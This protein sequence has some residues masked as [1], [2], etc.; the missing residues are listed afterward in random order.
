M[1]W[2]ILANPKTEI[3]VQSAL[4]YL[5]IN[6]RDMRPRCGPPG[7]HCTQMTSAFLSLMIAG[8]PWPPNSTRHTGSWIHFSFWGPHILCNAGC[9]VMG[10]GL[11]SHVDRPPSRIHPWS[12]SCDTDSSVLVTR[13]RPTGFVNSQLWPGSP[14][15]SLTALMLWCH[16]YRISLN[17][18]WLDVYKCPVVFR[19]CLFFFQFRLPLQKCCLLAQQKTGFREC[20]ET[21]PVSPLLVRAHACEEQKGKEPVQM[22]P[23]ENWAQTLVKQFVFPKELEFVSKLMFLPNA[24]WV[25]GKTFAQLSSNKNAS[26][27]AQLESSKPKT[28]SAFVAFK[29]LPLAFWCFCLGFLGHIAPSKAEK[30]CF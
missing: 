6:S 20:Q 22:S 11:N 28:L 10:I 3:L 29:L 1:Q 19:I 14:G 24:R 26:N 21:R 23:Q 15:G 5:P 12:L 2:I 13:S 4:E 16:N 18:F 9:Q 8:S 25:E 17:A 27:V 7:R 30:S